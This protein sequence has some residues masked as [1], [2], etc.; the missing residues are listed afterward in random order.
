M[1][2]EE[3]RLDLKSL[4]DD[5]KGTNFLKKALQVSL[6]PGGVLQII[7]CGYQEDYDKKYEKGSWENQFQDIANLLGV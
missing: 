6:H 3:D 4:K 7:A 5:P 2:D 1:L